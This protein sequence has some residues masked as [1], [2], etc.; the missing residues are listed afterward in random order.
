MLKSF[1]AKQKIIRRL[2]SLAK[3]D[4]FG[5]ISQLTHYTQ[6]NGND[7]EN[8]GKFITSSRYLLML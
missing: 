1:T 3:T 5:L 6:A 7:P 8:N 4:Y 2:S